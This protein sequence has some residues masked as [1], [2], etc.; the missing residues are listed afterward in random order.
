M[1][2]LTLWVL[3]SL[4]SSLSFAEIKVELEPSQV[5]MGETFKLSITQ[6]DQQGAEFPI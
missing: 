3:L 2:K 4:F 5:T 1:K 6:E